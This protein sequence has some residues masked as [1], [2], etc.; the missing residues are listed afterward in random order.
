[1]EKKQ[2]FLRLKAVKAVLRNKPLMYRINLYTPTFLPPQQQSEDGVLAIHC[3]TTAAFP[4]VLS[5]PE[6]PA[7]PAEPPVNRKARRAK[8]KGKK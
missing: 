3:A 7:P 1:M 4:Y 6:P 8:P 5:L 2:R